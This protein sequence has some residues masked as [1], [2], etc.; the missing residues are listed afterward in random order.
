[1]VISTNAP[2]FRFL[3]GWLSAKLFC[4]EET[5]HRIEAAVITAEEKTGAEIKV[6]IEGSLTILE[7][8]RGWTPQMRAQEIFTRHKMWDTADNNGVLVFVLLNQRAIEI[9]SDRGLSTELDTNY[10]KKL[11]DSFEGEV[12]SKGLLPAIVSIVQEIG[13]YCSVRYKRGESASESGR[14]TNTVI[15]N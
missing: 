9:V 10:W 5:L 11:C 8:I 1:M 3:P 14:L 13:A 12:H 4:T 15:R 6:C 2:W 7:R